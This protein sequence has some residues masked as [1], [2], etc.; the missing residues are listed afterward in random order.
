M[1]TP[2]WMSGQAHTLYDKPAIL[3]NSLVHLWLPWRDK[4]GGQ[5]IAIQR[6]TEKMFRKQ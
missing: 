2:D 1:P 5:E 6:R 4:P 3:T